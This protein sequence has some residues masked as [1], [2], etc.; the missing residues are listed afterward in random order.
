MKLRALAKLAYAEADPQRPFLLVCVIGIILSILWPTD[1]ASYRATG[2]EKT[3]LVLRTDHYLR[4]TN[5]IAQV[6]IPIIERDPVG[7]MQLV[8]V[9]VSTTFV[10]HGLKYLLDPVTIWGTRLGERPSGGRHN[11]PSGHS[12]M[13]SCALYFV[14]R[15]YGWRHALYMLPI[16]FLTMFARVELNVHTVSAVMAGA[17]VGLLMSALFTG[18]RIAPDAQTEYLVPVP[19]K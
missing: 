13:A 15:R 2:P 18:K 7:M 6:A 9:G 1:L 12:S 4:F 14:C 16:T 11:M 8:F 5:T 10:T 19:G 3:S 17:L